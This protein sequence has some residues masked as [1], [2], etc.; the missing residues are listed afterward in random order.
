[1][2]IAPGIAMLEIK[3]DIRGKPSVIHPTLMWDGAIAIL[4]DAGYPGQLPLIRAAIEQ[5]G[6]PFDKLNKVV[7]THHDIDHIG[8]LSQ[9]LKERDGDISVLGHAVEKAYIQGDKRPLKLAQMEANLDHLPEE[10][11]ILYG[12]LNAAFQACKVNVDETLDDGQELPYLGGITVIFTPGHTLGHICLYHK[13]SKTL[14]AGDALCVEE[15]MLAR[16]PAFTT[17]DAALYA[18]SLVK[19]AQYDIE[20]VICYHGGLYKDHANQ[21]LAALAHESR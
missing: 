18:Q 9:M 6:V 3:A 13:R 5:A 11:K 16:T 4:V 1:M 17:F 7:V 10:M 21:R 12:Q 14:I 2:E 15:G 8:S 19:L 20:T